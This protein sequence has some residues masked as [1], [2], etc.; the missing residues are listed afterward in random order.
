M[1]SENLAGSLFCPKAMQGKIYKYHT[2]VG[3][4]AHVNS[5]KI[6]AKET[7]QNLGITQMIPNQTKIPSKNMVLV[8]SFMPQLKA[9]L[10]VNS[11]LCIRVAHDKR[12]ILI[13]FWVGFLSDRGQDSLGK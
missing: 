7:K 8:S 1:W 10:R 5:G 11:S 2:K 13:I 4:N 6:G 9:F 3:R 12:L